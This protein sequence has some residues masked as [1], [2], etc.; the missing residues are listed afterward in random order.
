MNVI[1][2]LVLLVGLLVLEAMTAGL[3]SIWFAAGALAGALAAYFGAAIVVQLLLFIGISVVLFVFTRPLAIRFLKKG[4]T[5]TN[6][7]GLV[8]KT[9]VVSE[10][11]DNLAQ[12][13]KILVNDIDWMA[14]TED[15]RETIEKGAVVK[16]Q[17][18]QGVR[19]I[20]SKAAD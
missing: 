12:T 18:I 10:K 20:V 14:R 1:I 19:A 13:G 4:V 17:E 15:D 7:D 16:I 5:K 2:W 9:A 8:G 3:T 11:I 6:V